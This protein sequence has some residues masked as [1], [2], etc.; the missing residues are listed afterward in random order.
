M[1]ISGLNSGTA[2]FLNE[3]SVLN[4]DVSI[5]PPSSEL[6][7]HREH[8]YMEAATRFLERLN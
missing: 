3:T 1:Q 4:Q 8:P 6:R 5:I 2:F 7:L